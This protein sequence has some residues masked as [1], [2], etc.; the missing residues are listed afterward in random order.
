MSHYD[1]VLC[2]ILLKGNPLE[3]ALKSSCNHNCCEILYWALS[4]DISFTVFLVF[5]Y[6]NRLFLILLTAK[7]PEQTTLS[8]HTLQESITLCQVRIYFR[9]KTM[10]FKVVLRGRFEFFSCISLVKQFIFTLE[11]M[12]L[13]RSTVSV[14][15]SPNTCNDAN[16]C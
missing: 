12:F 14:Q 9:H 10:C 2:T 7:V 5:R 6:T 16:T 11:H 4:R 3:V 13:W 8:V 15:A 1:I